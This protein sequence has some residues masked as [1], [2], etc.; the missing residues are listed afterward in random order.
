VSDEHIRS[1]GGFLVPELYREQVAG[2]IRDSL[3]TFEA[4]RGGFDWNRE[5]GAPPS[6]WQKR[7]WRWSAR[8]NARRQRL[9]LRIAPWLERDDWE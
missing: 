9:A 8:L 3:P 2:Q 5:P 1:S 4:A 7:K 6:R